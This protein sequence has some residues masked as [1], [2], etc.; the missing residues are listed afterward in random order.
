MDQAL[1]Q[2]AMVAGAVDRLPPSED[3][4]ENERQTLER[5]ADALESLSEEFN[6]VVEDVGEI[7]IGDVE[8]GDLDDLDDM[9]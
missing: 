5:F 2:I 6:E 9:F 1:S 7:D 3:L 8:P 4:T